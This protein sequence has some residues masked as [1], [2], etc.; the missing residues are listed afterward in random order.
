MSSGNPPLKPSFSTLLNPFSF[1][2]NLFLYPGI[3]QNSIQ[4]HTNDMI[5]QVYSF[6][7]H[8]F[9]INIFVQPNEQGKKARV[10]V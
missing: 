4:L 1:K 10:K 9:F 6:L 2:W 3:S 8:N 5:K 7:P